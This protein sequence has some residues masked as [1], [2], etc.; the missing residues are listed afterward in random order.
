MQIITPTPSGTTIDTKLV[1]AITRNVEV[2]TIVIRSEQTNEDYI[3]SG[4]SASTLSFEVTGFSYYDD[5]EI[6]YS[7]DELQF[8]E[9][10]DF[11][12]TMYSISNEV[13]FKGKLY[14]TE[15]LPSIESNNGKYS[16]NKG[17][18]KPFKGNDSDNEY[19]VIE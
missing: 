6:T 9:G 8:N 7:T 18:Y 16:I 19:I 10:E 5:F 2:D 15:Q 17:E 1:S 13:L 14:V 11:Q 4:S 3:F 12:M